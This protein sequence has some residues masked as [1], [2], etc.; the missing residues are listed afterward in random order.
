MVAIKA[1][2]AKSMI[3]LLRLLCLSPSQ[4]QWSHKQ[5]EPPL[6]AISSEHQPSVSQA[7]QRGSKQSSLCISRSETL[8]HQHIRFWRDSKRSQTDPWTGLLAALAAVW[9]APWSCWSPR[10]LNWFCQSSSWEPE[11]WGFSDFLVRPVVGRKNNSKWW[12]KWPSGHDELCLSY[13][14]AG[15]IF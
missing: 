7:Y 12:S 4:M 10:T 11:P 3:Y 8:Q 9:V 1:V 2:T 6:F 13:K 14:I 15:N 5:S